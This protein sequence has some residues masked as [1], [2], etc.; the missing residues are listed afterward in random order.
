MANII[1]PREHQSA[2]KA[3][4][5]KAPANLPKARAIRVENDETRK[6]LP[7]HTGDSDT[8]EQPYPT[9]DL[10]QCVMDRSPDWT[11]E[12]ALEQFEK[13]L[14]DE[15]TKAQRWQGQERWQ[16]REN[17]AMRLVKIIH[18]HTFIDMLA[19]AGIAATRDADVERSPRNSRIW[20]N[21]FIAKMEIRPGEWVS[22]GRVGVNAWVYEPSEGKRIVKH[23]TTLQYPFGPEYSIM[24]FNKLNVPTQEKYRGWRTALLALIVKDVI[25]EEEALRAFGPAIGPAAEF[26]NSELFKF[27]NRRMLA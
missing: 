25:T 7:T 6:L 9:E 12:S 27:R 3:Q 8:L 17:E 24:N 22:S 19:R 11:V 2:P 4:Q 13:N 5:Y 1:I 26:Y 20:L 16:G 10:S 21:D 14:N 18:P 23:I 15:R